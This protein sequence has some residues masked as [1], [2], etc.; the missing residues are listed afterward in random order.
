MGP[1]GDHTDIQE[2][3]R[4]PM[5]DLTL[6]VRSLRHGTDDGIECVESEIRYAE[7]EWTVPAEAAA[8]VLV[9]CWAEHFIRSHAENSAR[10]MR[11]VLKPVLQAARAVGVTVVHAPSPTNVE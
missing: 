10:I 6:T 2:R 8:L 5:P 9:D 11:E 4:K 7:R 3:N 1:L